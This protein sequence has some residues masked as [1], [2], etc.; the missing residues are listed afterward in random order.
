M[1]AL[2]RFIAS[3]ERIRWTRFVLF[4]V[5]LAGYTHAIK[6]LQASPSIWAE[7]TVGILAGIPGVLAAFLLLGVVPPAKDSD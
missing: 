3:L 1:T 5:F 6:V 2:D 7:W 4:A